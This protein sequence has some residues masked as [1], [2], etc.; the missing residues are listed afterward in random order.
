MLDELRKLGVPRHRIIISS[1]LRLRNDG[2][3]RADAGEP[4]DPGVA[5]YWLTKTGETRCIAVDKYRNTWENMRAI[6]KTIDCIR[7]IERYGGAEIMDRAF[8]GFAQLPPP[9]ITQR[10]WREVLDPPEGVTT[11]MGLQGHYRRKAAILHPDRGGSHEAMA[12]LNQAWEDCKKEL[13]G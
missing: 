3:P 5:V 12:E 13:G 6:G 8:S 4:A 1:N 10:P 11:L 7:A 9:M 2:E